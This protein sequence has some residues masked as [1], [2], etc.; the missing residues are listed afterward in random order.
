M[1]KAIARH[2]F[3]DDGA[4][5]FVPVT[6]ANRMTTLTSGKVDILI[7]TMSITDNRQM[8]VRFSTPYYIAGQAIMVKDS[9]QAKSLRDF[10]GKRLIT[11]F[12]S[13][14]ERNLRTNVPDVE[15]A[16]P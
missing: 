8:V 1:A 14:S 13:T 10:R 12:G 16:E 3:A 11:V 7:A 2:I 6:A 9:S 5:E 4:V 15:V